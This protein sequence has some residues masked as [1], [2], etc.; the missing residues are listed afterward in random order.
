MGETW[1]HVSNDHRFRLEQ[2]WITTPEE[3][4][5]VSHRIRY[6]IGF[7]VPIMTKGEESQYFFRVFNE[8][9]MDLDKFDYWF[10]REGDKA[11]LNQNRLYAG[12][13][14]KFKRPS[15]IQAGV[16]WQHRPNTDFWRMVI[17]YSHNF[18]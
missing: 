13:G 6:S 9:F 1:E 15:S 17:S 14:Y 3:G 7:T 2:R 10:D 8:L 5:D 16:L 12:M 4:T 18:N 11:G